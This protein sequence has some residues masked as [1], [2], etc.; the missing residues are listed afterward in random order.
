MKV[1]PIPPGYLTFTESRSNPKKSP[2]FNSFDGSELKLKT[3]SGHFDTDVT[4]DLFFSLKSYVN[5]FERARFV[6]FFPTSL[7]QE[8]I[9]NELQYGAIA[10][11]TYRPHFSWFNDFVVEGGF[12]FQQ[13]ENESIRYSGEQ[14]R[15]QNLIRNQEFD[16]LIYGGF[17]QAVIQTGALVEACSCRSNRF[18]RRRL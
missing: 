2:S 18:C 1:K 17:L 4:S 7:Q 9:E 16:F 13:Q 10:T 14:R 5:K 3:V 11:L 12:D 15:R 6:K 8:R